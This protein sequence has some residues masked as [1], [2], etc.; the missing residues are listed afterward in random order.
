MAQFQSERIFRSVQ[1]SL[2]QNFAALDFDV[3]SFNPWILKIWLIL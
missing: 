1:S 2:G 3:P